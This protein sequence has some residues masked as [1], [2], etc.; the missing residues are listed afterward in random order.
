MNRLQSKFVAHS[1]LVLG[2][3]AL[4]SSSASAQLPQL[5]ASY[6]TQKTT[7][8]VWA[9]FV[10]QVQVKIKGR[11]P[12]TLKME[13]GHTSDDQTWG[14]SIPNVK[15]G[16]TYQYLINFNGQVQS[17]VDPR[18]Q[19][20][21]GSKSTSSS[22]VVDPSFNWSDPSF[23]NYKTPNFNE[24]VI[25]ELHIGSFNPASGNNKF[26]FS[27]AI[28][29]LDYLKQLG[30]NAIEVLPIHENPE[31][32]DHVPA[33][34]DWGY[35]PVQL[36]AIESSYGT[37][38]DFKEFVKQSHR[39]GIAV[40]VDVVYN[41]MSNDNLLNQFG[42]WSSN[43]NTNGIYF[44]D[45]SRI[46]TGFGPRFDYGR[47]QVRSYI[48]DNALMYLREYQVDGLRWDSTINIRAMKEGSLYRQLDDGVKLIREANDVYR[49]SVPKQPFKISIAEDLQSADIVVNPESNSC[50][51]CLGFNSQ[52]D[53]S[54]YASLKDAISPP[55][56]GSRNIFALK[57]AIQKKVGS[58][59]F[60]RI[61]YSENH[62]KVGHPENNE[63]RLP[64]IIDSASPTSIFAKKRSTLAAAVILTAPGIPLIFQGQ[65]M[66]DN[67]NFEFKNRSP[68][69]WSRTQTFKGIVQMYSDLISLRRNLTGTTR[70]L[71]AQNLN[72][73]HLDNTNK[74]LA[75]HRFDN[76][77]PKDDVVVVV[78]LSN[79]SFPSYNLGF[80][81]GGTW[82]VR[83][84]SGASIY[85]TGFNG[86]DSLDTQA[87]PGQMDNLNFN[88]NVGLG[89]YS[90]IILSQD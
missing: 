10:K 31:F 65:E 4:L 78:N 90:V 58:D 74:V 24:M 30:V 48:Q 53:E 36:F 72:V 12:V 87:I 44:Y 7:F 62:D 83:F 55:L 82:K 8:R 14:V 89:P 79:Q 61:I 18:S 39:R 11:A 84:N 21:T 28:E 6:Q 47:T 35:D 51:V 59:V 60:D 57:D 40:I 34:Y 43:S 37:S 3:L 67:H 41:H 1:G 9:P 19:Q 68:V 63:I 52:W 73:F 75:Y 2:I 85:D 77:G 15:P 54:L 88:G 13:P 86:G 27:G 70:G 71:V 26:S 22:V 16:D 49:N 66:L 23:P 5:G 81:R 38:K 17:F 33:E 46:D 50:N 64:L 25:Y 20:L 32:G 45:K 80:P 29:K 56:D 76:G 69:D 42:G